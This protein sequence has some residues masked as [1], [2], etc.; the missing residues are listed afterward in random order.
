MRLKNVAVA[1]VRHYEQL[2]GEKKHTGF[3]LDLRAAGK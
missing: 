2:T 3:G 1:Q